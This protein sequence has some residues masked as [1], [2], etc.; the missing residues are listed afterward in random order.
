MASHDPR[1]A[2]AFETF[3]AEFDLDRTKMGQLV[4]GTPPEPVSEELLRQ[5]ERRELEGA[6]ARKVAELVAVYKVWHEAA[7]RVAED[8][9]HRLD[10]HGP[11]DVG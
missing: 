6:A 1:S 7:I 3:L 11:A 5:Y 10:D 9:F 8:E 2:S 4:E